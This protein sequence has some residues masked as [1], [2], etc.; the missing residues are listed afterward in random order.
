[1]FAKII[2]TMK[3]ETKEQARF[4]AR[5]PREQKELFDKAAHLG[6]YR[7]LTDFIMHAAQ[8]KAK[9]IIREK[10]QSIASERD[11]QIF[12][13]ALT[14]PGKPSKT[15]KMALNDYNPI[16]SNSKHKDD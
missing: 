3:K 10:E 15:L 5:L 14:R 4:D 16:G 8:E 1:M 2:K 13:D 12:F 7:N 9:A 11:G 6:G